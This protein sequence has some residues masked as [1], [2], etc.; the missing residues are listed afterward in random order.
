MKS[1][2]T[3]KQCTKNIT[4]RRNKFCSSS[5]AASFNNRG[6]RRHG[7]PKSKCLHC[8][9]TNRSSFSKYCS[10]QC[11]WDYKTLKL[12]ETG[13]LGRLGEKGVRRILLKYRHHRC[14]ICKR[15]TWNK[16]PIPISVDHINGNPHDN[17]VSNLRLICWN[18]HAQTPTFGN[19]N[20]GNGR[21]NRYS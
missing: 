7:K 8:N 1:S 19:K 21:K 17:S 10:N 12:Y 13:N 14:E 16:K 6:V 4:N 11:H 9:K 3:C 20:K 15:K 5:C 2:S 18:C